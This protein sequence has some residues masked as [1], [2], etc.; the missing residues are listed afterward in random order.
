MCAYLAVL[1]VNRDCW[2]LLVCQFQKVLESGWSCQHQQNDKG[3][4]CSVAWEKRR[5][6]S[7]SGS[8]WLSGWR[9]TLAVPPVPG[10]LMGEAR[11]RQPKHKLAK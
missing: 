2:L 5:V 8:L 7:S 11:Y 3:L 6:V 4:K 1:S 9:K 10:R